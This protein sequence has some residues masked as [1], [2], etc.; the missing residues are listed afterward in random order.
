M[1]IAEVAA[2]TVNSF[3]ASRVKVQPVNVIYSTSMDLQPA[4]V[5]WIR[6]QTLTDVVIEKM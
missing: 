5:E 4:I 3:G 6:I 1:V 2:N